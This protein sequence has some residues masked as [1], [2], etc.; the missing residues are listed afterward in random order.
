LP[1]RRPDH[2][3]I[4]SHDSSRRN[5]VTSGAPPVAQRNGNGILGRILSNDI[6]VELVTT[7]V[8]VTVLRP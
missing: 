1:T 4:C 5:D 6:F 2:D 8:G 7:C 3:I